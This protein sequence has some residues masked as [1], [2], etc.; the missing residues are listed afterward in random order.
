MPI[1]QRSKHNMRN[2]QTKTCFPS[3]ANSQRNQRR[4]R[5]RLMQRTKKR[6]H[7]VVSTL[8]IKASNRLS[9]PPCKSLQSRSKVSRRSKCLASSSKRSGGS[10]ST[11]PATIQL[12][13]CQKMT[14]NTARNLRASTRRT[15]QSS[16][17]L[18]TYSMSQ[19]RA[20]SAHPNDALT[21][22]KI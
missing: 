3:S 20:T 22:N 18:G 2:R 13:D 4:N 9:K 5:R 16:P 14:K 15:H 19:A 11:R 8:S 10:R 1:G 17:R 7:S 6:S 21:S 12:T